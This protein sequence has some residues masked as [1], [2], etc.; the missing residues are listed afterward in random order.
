MPRLARESWSSPSSY[1]HHW[2]RLSWRDFPFLDWL[3]EIDIGNISDSGSVHTRESSGFFVCW[4][5]DRSRVY[6]CCINTLL[7]I[8]TQALIGNYSTHRHG[9]GSL[10]G[11][12]R[13]K[14]RTQQMSALGWAIVLLGHGDVYQPCCSICCLEKNY[15][16]K[17]RWMW[18]STESGRDWEV[19]WT[20]SPLCSGK[21]YCLR[22][23]SARKEEH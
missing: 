18:D 19:F 3:R 9:G 7:A 16:A 21:C 2:A 15:K 6:V 8:C 10:I 13:C 20:E 12:D 17:S 5:S 22:R 23:I 1:A 14:S 11:T 4:A